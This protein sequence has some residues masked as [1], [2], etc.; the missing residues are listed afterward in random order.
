MEAARR[1]AREKPVV[2]LKSGR[3]EAGQAAVSSHTGAVAGQSRV[4]DAA[5]AQAGVIQAGSA[6]E[7]RLFSKSLAT[8]G[9][10]R[11]SRVAVV[12]FSGGGAVLAVD[13]L[14]RAGL[15]LAELSN[16]TIEAIRDLFPDWMGMS[17]P[18]DIWIPVARDLHHAFPRIMNAV[19]ADDGVEA[20]ICIYCSY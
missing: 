5:F 16:E 9:D 12:S 2:V 4:Y 10:M 7:L 15:A 8:Y 18:L 11:G 13:A 19:L 3:T 14:D 17:N 20:V 1:I 6:E